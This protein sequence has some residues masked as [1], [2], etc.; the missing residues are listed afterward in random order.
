MYGDTAVVRALAR[1]V[2]DRGRQIRSEADD[3]AG[4]AESVPWCGLAAEAMRRLAGEHAATLRSCAGA[5]EGAA[6]AL[7]R[8]AREV[9][10]LKDLIA[11]IEHRVLGLIESAGSGLAGVVG[12]VLPDAVGRW[13]QDFDPPPPGSREWLDVQLP[14]SA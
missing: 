2:R 8:H 12:H 14:R 13:V 11:S 4:R 10:H 7:D 1:Q 6:D 5:H 3:L 9:D